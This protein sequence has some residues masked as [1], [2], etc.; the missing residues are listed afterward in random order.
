MVKPLVILIGAGGSGGHI[1]PA[2]SIAEACRQLGHTVHWVGTQ[3]GL[4]ARLVPAHEFPLHFLDMQRLRGKGLLAWCK[5]PWRLWRAW[6]QASLIIKKLQPAYVLTF[7]GFVSAPVGLAAWSLKVP[8]FVHEQNAII[9]LTNKLLSYG[10]RKVFAGFPY[11][12]S[13]G[14]LSFARHKVVYTGNPLRLPLMQREARTPLHQRSPKTLRILVIGGS[15]GARILNTT[16]PL[17]LAKCTVARLEVVHQVGNAIEIVRQAYCT[18][19]PN[20]PVNVVSFIDDMPA[21]YAWADLVIARS[22]AMTVAELAM[23]GVAS[24]L[25]PLKIAVDNHQFANAKYL[26]DRG[27]ALIVPEEVC[28]PEKIAGLLD[29]FFSHPE[30]IYRMVAIAL[31]HAKT[32]VVEQILEYLHA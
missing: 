20:T 5:L 27:A 29:H 14:F 32:H 9:G 18:H 6:R 2:L 17:A 4:E 12:A 7:G 11:L 15:Q 30:H 31:Q 3:H 8:Y 16:L 13:R 22:G 24:I 26:S 10:A 25:V 28:T 23:Q 1:F 21:A 19:V